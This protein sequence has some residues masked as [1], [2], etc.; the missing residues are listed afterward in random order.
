MHGQVTHASSLH[1]FERLSLD[2]SYVG[3]F[4]F[5]SHPTRSLISSF[6]LPLSQVYHDMCT[7]VSDTSVS[8]GQVSFHNTRRCAIQIS[9]ATYLYTSNL[10]Q[11]LAKTSRVIPHGYKKSVRVVNVKSL[12]FFHRSIFIDKNSCYMME[13]KEKTP[14]SPDSGLGHF[15]QNIARFHGKTLGGREMQT[16]FEHPEVQSLFKTSFVHFT[17][18]LSDCCC[19]LDCLIQRLT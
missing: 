7:S 13:M 1:S 8:P 6:S 14:S 17:C 5:F 16:F 11:S 4:V 3:G 19:F 9:Q 2:S 18:H 12:F 10:S 15:W